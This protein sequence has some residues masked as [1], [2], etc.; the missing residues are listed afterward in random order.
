M[1]FA[2]LSGG[3]GAGAFIDS[4]HLVRTALRDIPHKIVGFLITPLPFQSNEKESVLTA[5]RFAAWRELAQFID[6]S[7]VSALTKPDEQKRYIHSGKPFD[8]LFILNFSS[9]SPQEAGNESKIPMDLL[10]DYALRLSLH[11]KAKYREDQKVD[12]A[13]YLY[14]D[15]FSEK[16]SVHNIGD[17][18]FSLLNLENR[19]RKREK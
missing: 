8:E 1:I 13:K 12:V 9:A 3:T 16:Y 15:Q 6:P 4:A 17:D 18:A 11:Q 19:L 5:R 14:I 2:S 10:L 7:N